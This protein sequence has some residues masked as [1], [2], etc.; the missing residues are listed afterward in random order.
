MSNTALQR[1]RNLN[2]FEDGFCLEKKITLRAFQLR[3]TLH[4]SRIYPREKTFQVHWMCL[5]LLNQKA[6]SGSFS[7]YY[8]SGTC[9]KYYVIKLG[10]GG[11][12]QTAEQRH[13]CQCKQQ[14]E[15]LC[16]KLGRPH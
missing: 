14:S 12:A 8:P 7:F 4:V 11:S 13:L 3:Y 5:K 9:S 15:Y 1:L 6:D 10:E 2:V 16:A